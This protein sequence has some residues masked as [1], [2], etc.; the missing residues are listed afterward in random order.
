MEKE[1]CLEIPEEGGKKEAAA[2]GEQGGKKALT[3]GE[4]LSLY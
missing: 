3:L 4:K 1:D 2:Q